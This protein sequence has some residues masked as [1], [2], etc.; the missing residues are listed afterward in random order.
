MINQSR[1]DIRRVLLISYYFPPM[2]LSGV[3]RTSKFV[4]YLPEFNWE[5]IV[6]TSSPKS[7]YAFDE[8]LQRELDETK[9]KVFRTGISTS[10]KLKKFPRN[11]LIQNIGRIILSFFLQPDTKVLWKRKAIE[12]GREI[13][14]N[15]KVD[16]IFATAPPFTDFLIAQELSK[17]FNIPFVVDYRDVWVDNPFHF[18]PTFA[19]KMYV[20]KLEE[21]VLKEASRIIV[22]F[23]GTKDV[24]L[25]KY[26]FLKSDEVIIIPHGYDK[27]DFEMVEDIR[28]DPNKFVVTHSGLFQDNRN[29]KFFLKAFAKFVEVR[30]DGIPKEAWFV[31]LMRKSHIKLIKKFNLETKVKLFGYQPHSEVVRLLKMSNLL[32]LMFEDNVRSPGKLYEYFGA[33][34]P[35][36]ICAP[37]GYMKSLALES[38]SAI[39]VEPRD[40]EGIYRALNT[41]YD[42]WRNE[43]LPEPSDSFLEKFDRKILTEQLSLQLALACRI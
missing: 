15:H 9:A 8:E 20:R 39:G 21:N 29:P 31:G 11:I 12:L 5:P 37:D 28:P 14:S 19:H 1:M 34:K 30:N 16:V 4:K 10:R 23:R 42:L 43:T 41:F 3:Q 32:W 6:L 25:T 26:P 40:V 35:V 17:E 24:L 33:K 38:D 2:G 36:L 13:L 22:T 18:F 27:K 7:Y